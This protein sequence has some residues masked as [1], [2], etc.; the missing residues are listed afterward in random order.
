MLND[1]INDIKF[2]NVMKNIYNELSDDTEI[3]DK[4]FELIYTDISNIYKDTSI[5]LDNS[6]IT[7]ILSDPSTLESIRRHVQLT[8]DDKLS[9]YNINMKK[10]KY[11][12]INLSVLLFKVVTINDNIV[13]VIKRY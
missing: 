13:Q 12:K 4:A 7:I 9:D 1:I 8:I 3:F 11:N 10:S 5:N 2:S 6:V